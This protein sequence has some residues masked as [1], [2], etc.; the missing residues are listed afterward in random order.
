MIALFGRCEGRGFTIAGAAGRGGIA[1]QAEADVRPWT[2]SRRVAAIAYAH[3]LAG[4][5]SPAADGL[6]TPSQRKS[7]P[8]SLSASPRYSRSFLTRFGHT[9]LGAAH[10]LFCQAFR[11]SKLALDSPIWCSS[12]RVGRLRM[13]IRH[14]KPTRKGRVRDC[15]APR[16]EPA[17]GAGDGWLGDNDASADAR[18]RVLGCHPSQP[19][20]QFPAAALFS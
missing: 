13:R 16:H 15:R 7:R 9:G 6:R 17:S 12:V 10:G 2:L 8:L 5:P 4:L 14:S 20:S 19:A 11:Q 1:D 18:L 3:D